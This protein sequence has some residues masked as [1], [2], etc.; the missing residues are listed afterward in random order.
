MSPCITI[1]RPDILI[2][3]DIAGDTAFSYIP[4]HFRLYSVLMPNVK[5]ELSMTPSPPPTISPSRTSASP[6][7]KTNLSPGKA[8]SGAV[9]TKKTGAWSGQEL[10][11]LYAIMCPKKVSRG[12]TSSPGSLRFDAFCLFRMVSVLVIR[13]FRVIL[14]VI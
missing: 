3:V 10:K 8:K 6:S 9:G 5:R 1:S 11:Q 2:L 13:D 14:M 4:V 7:K 12:W